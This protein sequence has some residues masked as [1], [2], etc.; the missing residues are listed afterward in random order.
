M[1]KTLIAP[2]TLQENYRTGSW[3]VVDCRFDLKDTDAGRRAYEMSHIP[4][5]VYAHLDD[6]LSG[7]IIPGQTGRHPLPS[8]EDAVALFSLW[9]IDESVQVVAYDDKGGGIASR[10]WWMLRWLGHEAVAVLDGGWP[11][12]QEAGLPVS[13]LPASVRPRQFRAKANSL[14]TVDA[15]GVDRARRGDEIK[16]VDSRTAERYRGE[17]EPIDPVAGHIPNAINLP[18]PEN[19]AEGKFLAPDL[20]KARFEKALGEQS[21]EKVIFYCGSGVTACHNLLAY[22]H[23]GLG[24][25]VLYPGSWSEWITDEGRAVE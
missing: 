7:R 11:A 19:L 10:L 25:A 3:V 21:P 2:A 4:S 1:Y 15:A 6:D 17:V 8:V 20:L 12:W 13:D 22:A 14:P 9:G 24:D 18:F 16:V 5:A 23:A